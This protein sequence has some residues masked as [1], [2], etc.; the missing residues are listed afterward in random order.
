MPRIEAE[1]FV[2]WEDGPDEVGVVDIRVDDE[3]Y[4]GSFIGRPRAMAQKLEDDE[5][6]GLS[7]YVR[8]MRGSGL[9]GYLAG[10]EVAEQGVGIGSQLVRGMLEEFKKLG[11]KVVVLHRS[12][13][14]RSSDEQLHAFY[15]R[16]GFED[17]DCCDEDIWPVMRLNLRR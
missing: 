11:V 6:F 2:D 13:G 4:L 14:Q 7:E 10:M 5:F 12:T 8:K 17:V 3:T 1:V 15:S 9:V 16:F